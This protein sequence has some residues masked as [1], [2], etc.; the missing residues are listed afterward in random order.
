M[1]VANIILK[2]EIL[3]GLNLSSRMRKNCPPIL[4]WLNMGQEVLAI[5]TKEKNV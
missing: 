3:K 1:P 2:A 5:A 4:I